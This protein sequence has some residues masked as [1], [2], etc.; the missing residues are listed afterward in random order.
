MKDSVAI[1]LVLLLAGIGGYVLGTS[2]SSSTK[3]TQE[4]VEG[5]GPSL[6]GPPRTSDPGNWRQA[7]GRPLSFRPEQTEDEREEFEQA[8]RS[9]GKD[10]NPIERYASLARLLENLSPETLPQVLEAFKKI[11]PTSEYHNE[12][13]ML[14]FAWTKFDR[15]GAIKFVDEMA[16]SGIGGEMSLSKE[17]LLKPVL[18]SWA[19]ENPKQALEWF[20]YLP[21][22]QQTH[23][24]KMSLMSGWATNNPSEATEY[25]QTQPAGQEREYLIGQIAA[26]MFS[27][28]PAE[29]S[30]WAEGIED[31]KFKEQVFEELAEDWVSVDPKGLASWLKGHADKQYSWEAIEDLGRGWV[32]TDSDAATAW[33]ENLP[34]GQAKQKGIEKMAQS[35]AENDLLAMG[36]WLNGLPDSPTTDRGVKAYSERLMDQ[37]PASALDSAMSITDDGIRNKTVQEISQQWF[38]ED[39][40]SAISWANNNS[41]PPEAM[42]RTLENLAEMTADQLQ[43][44]GKEINRDQI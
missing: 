13:Q 31:K 5:H 28:S 12:Y 17:E 41:Y 10:A 37:A 8:L 1:G 40:D 35:W 27:K 14:L 18:A 38:N 26:Q 25:L 7:P 2:G 22:D 11:P 3:V 6:G 15:A 30:S 34:D 32:A 24:L 33:F 43:Q 9:L 23:H 42:E 36:E 44:I 16:D 39:P 20:Q 4:T 21:E 29:A 19:S